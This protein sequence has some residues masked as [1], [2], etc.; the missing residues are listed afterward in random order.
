M[1]SCS[2]SL[3]LSVEDGGPGSPGDDVKGQV[4]TLVGPEDPET[5]TRKKSPGVA[6]AQTD[7]PKQETP[8]AQLIYRAFLSTPRRAMTLQE[9]YQWFRE[10]TD[11]GKD[12][13]KGWQNSIRHNLSMNQVCSSQPRP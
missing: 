8:Y 5:R 13:S 11:K 1:S 7:G 6:H 9:I 3:R 12:D 4:E 10:N 2:A